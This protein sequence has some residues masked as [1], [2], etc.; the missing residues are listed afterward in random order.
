MPVTTTEPT[1]HIELDI[2]LGLYM[3]LK[4]AER[5][6]SKRTFWEGFLLR[7]LRASVRRWGEDN[8][9]GVEIEVLLHQTGGEL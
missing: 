4:H 9:D 7:L 8:G 6:D 5:H 2:P 1:V 3:A